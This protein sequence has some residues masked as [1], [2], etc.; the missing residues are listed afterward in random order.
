MIDHLLCHARW[1]TTLI[2]GVIVERNARGRPRQD[3]RDVIK[4]AKKYAKV[5]ILHLEGKKL[6]PH[7][8][9]S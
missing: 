2:E 3:Y 9:M 4:G 1:F 8:P 5:E 6:Q 7:Q